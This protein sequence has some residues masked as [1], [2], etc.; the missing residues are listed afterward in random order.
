MTIGV[1]ILRVWC[2][3]QLPSC[4][5]LNLLFIEARESIGM[6][7]LNASGASGSNAGHEGQA[8]SS[9]RLLAKDQND[10][11][12][13]SGEF[14]CI[15]VTLGITCYKQTGDNHQPGGHRTPSYTSQP[16]DSG[17]EKLPLIRDFD[18]NANAFWSLHMKEAKSHDEARIESIKDD[19]DGVLI[20]VCI[21]ISPEFSGQS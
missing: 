19:M 16:T 2:S 3:L 9:T 18:D 11:R 8:D 14:P 13:N 15:L 21:Y 20:F 6:S 17:S 10:G 1:L 4:S 12:S 7:E 5:S